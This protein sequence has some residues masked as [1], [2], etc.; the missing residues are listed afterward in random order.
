MNG[1]VIR[2]A[3]IRAYSYSEKIA[4][5]GFELAYEYTRIRV[6]YESSVFSNKPPPAGIL[7]F[8]LSSE[9]ISSLIAHI[10][11]AFTIIPHKGFRCIDI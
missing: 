4:P 7:T 5:I 3:S 10:A 8:M 1:D 6:H 2:N 11:I 9:Q